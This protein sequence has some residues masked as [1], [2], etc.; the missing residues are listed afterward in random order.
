M[1]YQFVTLAVENRIATL[2]INRPDKLN[3][4]NVATIAEL[5]EAIEIRAENPH[6]QVRR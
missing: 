3:A 1:S 5:G 4:L 6:R 2:T